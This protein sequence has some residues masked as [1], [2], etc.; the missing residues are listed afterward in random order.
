MR[1]LKRKKNILFLL[2]DQVNAKLPPEISCV[3]EE[4]KSFI[5]LT[6]GGPRLR[7]GGAESG[8]QSHSRSC[9]ARE[10]CAYTNSTA[11]LEMLMC[12]KKKHGSVRN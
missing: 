7:P 3:N 6:P 4:E 11:A 2:V 5:T 10:T 1:V 9:R 8:R 12:Q